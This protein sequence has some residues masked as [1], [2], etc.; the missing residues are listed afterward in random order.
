MI[1]W[2]GIIIAIAFAPLALATARTAFSFW[3]F[4]ASWA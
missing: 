1:L 2:Q 3:I 4:F